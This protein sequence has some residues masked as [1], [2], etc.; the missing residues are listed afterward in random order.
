MLASPTASMTA[1][2]GAGR[3]LDAATILAAMRASRRP[4]GVPDEIETSQIAERV[5]E[6]VWT[7]D[8]EPWDTL[9]VGG[10]CGPQQCTL[11]VQGARDGTEGTDAWAFSVDPVSGSVDVVEHTLAALPAPLVE[12]LDGLA[13]DHETLDGLV[14]TSARWLGPEAPS[15]FV[16]SYREGD[17]EGSCSVDVTVDADGRR[18]VDVARAG[19]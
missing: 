7:V 1:T 11:E 13:R 17:E 19:C 2:P 10:A 14:R 6:A 12:D 4:G 9:T 16:L 5:A 15:R 3:P 8:G 18:I